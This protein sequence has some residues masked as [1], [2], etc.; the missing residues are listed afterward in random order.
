MLAFC[1]LPFSL[2]IDA[3]SFWIL[4]DIFSRSLLILVSSFWIFI[5]ASCEWRLVANYLSLLFVATG[6]LFY[7]EVYNEILICKADYTISKH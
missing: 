2:G 3:V 5:Q 4:L 1:T 6:I 7:F